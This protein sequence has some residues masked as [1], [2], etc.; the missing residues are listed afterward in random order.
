MVVEMNKT[1][2]MLK[3]EAPPAACWYVACVH[4]GREKLAKLHLERQ[5]FGTYLPMRAGGMVKGEPTIRPFLTGYIFV[6]VD[7]AKPG[8]RAINSTIGVS[9]LLCVG[10]VPRP[11]PVGLV[12]R[13][14]RRE[15]FGLVKLND[16]KDTAA[17]KF[18]H[19][20]KVKVA[21]LDIDGIFDAVDANRSRALVSLLGS[22]SMRLTVALA[23][24][25]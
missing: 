8:W 18:A 13:I 11:V 9:R 7:M 2:E 14:Q 6:Q 16:P 15:V 12:E 4:S 25:S 19:G 10:D 5:G 3:K 21:G 17:A 24:L 23:K 22:N 20:Q 1:E